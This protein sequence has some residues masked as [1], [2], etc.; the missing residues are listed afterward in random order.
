MYDGSTVRE[1]LIVN[2]ELR[3]SLMFFIPPQAAFV[4]MSEECAWGM[5]T[6][7]GQANYIAPLQPVTL[8]SVKTW[9]IRGELAV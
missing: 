3:E 1:K 6:K 4:L 2:D 7:N 5:G 9:G 8:A